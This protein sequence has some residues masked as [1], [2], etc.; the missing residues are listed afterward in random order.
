MGGAVSGVNVTESSGLPGATNNIR[1]RGG[2]SITGG[3]EPLYVIDGVLVYNSNDATSTGVSHATNDF[4]PLSAINPND[5]ESIEILKDVSATAIYGSRGANGVII[6]TTKSGKKGRRNIE[7]QYSIGWQ[8]VAKTLDLLNAQQWGELFLEVASPALLESSGVTAAKVAS[9]GTGSDWQDAA[10]RSATTQNHQLSISGGDDKTRYLISGNFSDQDG[11]LVNTGF[12]RYAGRLNFERDLYQ[13]LTVGV[14]ISASK[15]EQNGIT[16]FNSYQ[17]Y[18]GGNSNAFEYVL[19]IPQAV[20]IYNADG[21]YNY[22][23][24]ADNFS[25]V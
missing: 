9:W 24:S 12:K 10:L 25:M 6:V 21:S 13:F 16:D 1:I 5:I 18:V 2:N 22:L 19:R 15:S 23:K 14:N 11:I 20:P 17:S 4:N 3:N 7:Y 8:K